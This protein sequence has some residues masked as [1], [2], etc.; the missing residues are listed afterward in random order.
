MIDVK[1]AV[2]VANEHAYYFFANENNLENLRLEEVEL[3]E[4][5]PEP[6][7]MITLGFDVRESRNSSKSNDSLSVI[8][9]TPPTRTYK[10]F[11]INANTGEFK[12]VKIRKI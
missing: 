4:D 2:Q 6:Y 12:A 11:K 3:S 10:E 7:W 9:N 5:L 1:Q 8:I